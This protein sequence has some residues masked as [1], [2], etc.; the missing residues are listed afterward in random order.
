MHD[1]LIMGPQAWMDSLQRFCSYKQ[2]TGIRAKVVT[3]EDAA[4][5]PGVDL[6]DRIKRRIER[7]HRVDG[8]SL[9]MLVGDADQFPV[10]Y[11]KAINTEW[12][13]MWY[14][15]DLYYADLYDSAGA[16]EDWDADADGIYAEL[17]FSETGNGAK[18]NIDKVNLYADVAVGRVPASTEAE[19]STYFDKVMAY[20]FSARESLAYGYPSDW[21]RDA[22]FVSGEGFGAKSDLHVVPLDDAGFRIIRRYRDDPVWSG[23][24][25]PQRRQEFRRLLGEGTGFLHVSAHGNVGGFRGWC[26]AQDVADLNNGS[27]LPIVVAM[28]CLTA[29]F[30]IDKNSYLTAMG[31][32][33]IGTDQF[34]AERPQPAHL[35]PK[36][37]SDS[38]AEAFLVRRDNGAIA[39]L[40]VTHKMEHGGDP[41]GRYFFEAYRDLPKPPTLGSM[42]RRALN[43]FVANDLGGGTIGMGPYYAFIHAHKVMMFGDPSLRVGGLAHLGWP[44]PSSGL[45]PELIQAAVG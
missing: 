19:A 30:H 31:T 15:S 28:S 21:F 6:P 1:L 32:S 25:D 2:D 12:G 4:S 38:M 8:V 42:W 24:I 5:E 18:F 34:L 44:K 40:G 10:R 41:L 11:I 43:Q 33:W 3:I 22:V 23:D 7:E 27:R 14:A 17:D 37:D 35:Q 26:T 29:R 16:F 9:V 36:H 39:Y 45:D 13:A 20:E